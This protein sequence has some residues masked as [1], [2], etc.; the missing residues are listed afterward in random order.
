MD[1][2]DEVVML[3]RMAEGL[4]KDFGTELTKGRLTLGKRER[5]R[6]REREMKE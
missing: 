1:P 5:E 6:E 4:R 3:R 2:N